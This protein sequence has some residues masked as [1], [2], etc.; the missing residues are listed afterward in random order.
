M[1][2]IRANKICIV[3]LSALGDIVHTLGMVNGLR[4]GYPDSHLTWILQPI[5]FSMV[6]HQKNIDR[7]IVFERNG[8]LSS[9]KNLRRELK[10]EHFDM[11]LM[12]QVSIKANIISM[13]INGDVKLGFD[14]KR[15]REMHW[16]F[17]N[18][19]IPY[20]QPQHVQDQFFEFLDYLDIKNYLKEWNFVFAEEE[21]EYRRSFFMDIGRPV[22]SF[23]I[24]SSNPEKDWQAEKYARVMDFVDHKLDMQPMIIGGP[25][26][27]EQEVAD[28]VCQYCRSRPIIALEKPIRR[29]MLQISGSKLVVSPDTGPLHMAVAMNI[30]TIGLYGFSNP[31][32]CGPYVFKDLLIDKYNDSKNEEAPITRVTKKG[33]MDRITHE[34]VIEK[35]EIAVKRYNLINTALP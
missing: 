8:G 3:R 10:G 25:S 14:F 35:I 29:T 7:F 31:R 28:N 21:R 26:K 16:I 5:P 1:P 34:E 33:R 13:I 4:K 27:R 23:V 15:S 24:A 9:W 32:R 22:V 18:K 11:V 17:A 12:L 2:K 19:R 6:K 20:H 30:P